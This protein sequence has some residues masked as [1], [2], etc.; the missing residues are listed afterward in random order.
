[1]ERSKLQPKPSTQ[2]LS[3]MSPL[4]FANS[5]CKIIDSYEVVKVRVNDSIESKLTVTPESMSQRLCELPME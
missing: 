5:R 2:P 4:G 1:M 3:P